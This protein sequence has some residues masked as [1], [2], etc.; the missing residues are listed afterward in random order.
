MMLLLSANGDIVPHRESVESINGSHGKLPPPPASF[1]AFLDD[2]EDNA[3]AHLQHSFFSLR[4]D[5]PHKK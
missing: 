2:D 5:H 1:S 3:D 4:L